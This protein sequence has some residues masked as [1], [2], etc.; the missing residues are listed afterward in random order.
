MSYKGTV[1]N[2]K[3]P[4]RGA[5]PNPRTRGLRNTK[6]RCDEHREKSNDKKEKKG[7]CKSTKEIATV[8]EQ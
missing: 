4:S 2:E 1:A 3:V 7:L 5:R 6:R 8:V